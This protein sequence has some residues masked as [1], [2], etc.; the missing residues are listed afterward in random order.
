[1]T[2]KQCAHV[3]ASGELCGG[4]AIVGSRYCFAHDPAQ[5]EKREEARR[6]GGEAGRIA[7]LT[8]SDVALRSIG[9]VL[10]L[11]ELTINDVRAGRVDVKVANAVGYL[12]NIAIRAIEGSE[13][14]VRLDA[15][16]SV[17]EPERARIVAGRRR[18][19]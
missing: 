5:A 13:L 7:P 9:D 12:A 17:L 16:E 19:A 15:L 18:V 2:G 14:E 4:F 1:M 11:M 10:G 6:R 3:K 8:E